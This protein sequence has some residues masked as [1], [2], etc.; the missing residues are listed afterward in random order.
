M[1]PRRPLNIV[2]LK[3][4]FATVDTERAGSTWVLNFT[5]SDKA[6]LDKAPL[7]ILCHDKSLGSP[8]VYGAIDGDGVARP[9]AKA[10]FLLVETI[11]KLEFG[12][13][14]P[15]SCLPSE[16]SQ[17]LPTNIPE[18]ANLYNAVRESEVDVIVFMSPSS[19]CSEFVRLLRLQA[20]PELLSR[21]YLIE[22][23][24]E[25]GKKEPPCTWEGE[26]LELYN[27]DYKDQFKQAAEGYN[28]NGPIMGISPTTS[29]DKTDIVETVLHLTKKNVRGSKDIPSG[30][31]EQ[32][33]S[34][35]EGGLGAHNRA[36]GGLRA[37]LGSD[38][39]RRP[40]VLSIESFM[41][42]LE[43]PNEPEFPV[44]VDF[45]VNMYLDPAVSQRPIFMIS[46]GTP[47]PR[48]VDDMR[49][50]LGIGCT[51]GKILAAIVPGINPKDWHKTFFPEAGRFH[52]ILSAC[53]VNEELKVA[54]AAL[55]DG[56][57]GE[58]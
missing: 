57:A 49:I 2:C 18:V 43:L 20:S 58:H 14:T 33:R 37:Y 31:S 45:T 39:D 5:D 12:D 26:Y 50:L 8:K 4:A 1:A 44:L 27:A 21:E 46:Q 3:G 54:V 48:A 15:P 56:E 25:V 35:T 38:A 36:L 11:A 28:K 30:V 52:D 6:K 55:P 7:V 22:S 19:D 10:S 53:L 41:E 17:S 32:P 47:F 24:Q 42:D 13:W 9:L 34:H 51:N 40:R 16:S 23:I 29:K